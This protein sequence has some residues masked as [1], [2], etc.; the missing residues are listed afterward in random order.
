MQDPGSVH[1]YIPAWSVG[2]V[3]LGCAKA[4][5]GTTHHLENTPKCRTGRAE[6]LYLLLLAGGPLSQVPSTGPLRPH[7]L[8]PCPRGSPCANGW[9]RGVGCHD[10]LGLGF[11][12]QVPVD[13][14][15]EG[16][17]PHGT[18]GAPHMC[19]GFSAHK[20]QGDRLPGRCGVHS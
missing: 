10:W 16:R 12:P 7:V 5:N 15:A 18:A 6:L 9:P 3:P 17:V 11:A 20:S 14:W 4:H 19:V 2:D 8:Q 1:L 13:L